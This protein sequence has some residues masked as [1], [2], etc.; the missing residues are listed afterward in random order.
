MDSGGLQTRQMGRG[1]SKKLSLPLLRCEAPQKKF[2]PVRRP[3][4]TGPDKEFSRLARI[5]VFL[6]VSPHC[7]LAL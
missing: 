5:P 3:Q 7:K 1:N 2:C 6:T 4:P